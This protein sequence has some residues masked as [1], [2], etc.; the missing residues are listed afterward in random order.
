MSNVTSIASSLT[1]YSEPDFSLI[2]QSTKDISRLAVFQSEKLMAV[3]DNAQRASGYVLD[4]DKVMG[5]TL[6]SVSTQAQ[7]LDFTELFSQVAEIDREIAKGKLSA[8]ELKAANEAREEQSDLFAT[9]N[10]NI[11]AELRSAAGAVRQKADEVRAVVLVER[12]QEA[13]AHQEKL[14]QKL[15]KSV[16]D[17][18]AARRSL[19]EDR[20]KI[21]AAQAVIRARNLI[22]VY[23]DF[24]PKDLEK[25]DLKKPEAEAIRLGVE[26]L[27]RLMGE[28][29]EG[30]KYSD[31][32]DQRKTFDRQIDKLDIDIKDL[33][34]EQR[35]NDPL[36]SD[37]RAVVTIDDKRAAVLGEAG[38]LPAAFSGFADELD[39]LNGPAVTEAS[40]TKVVNAIKTYTTN[41]LDARNRVIIT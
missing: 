11:K 1:S 24:I 19:D 25:L 4:L 37:L 33:I 35:A 18:R 32:A 13:L 28:V 16:A 8:E 39:K 15:S 21:I 31:L 22:D 5:E 9:Q 14:Q 41:C 27:K 23:K 17:K 12:T 38:K 7:N 29:S 26:V 40:V 3:V 30:F 20:S 6:V 10:R 36:M 2:A 34:A